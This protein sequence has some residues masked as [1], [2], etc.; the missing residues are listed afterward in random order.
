MDD[1]RLSEL[2]VSEYRNF[3]RGLSVLL[4]NGIGRNEAINILLDGITRRRRLNEE[5]RNFYRQKI[6]A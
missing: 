6:G 5:N 1:Y 2:T 4:A 3:R